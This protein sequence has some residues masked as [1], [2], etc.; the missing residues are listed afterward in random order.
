M[1]ITVNRPA[2]RTWNFLGVNGAKIEWG[3]GT[4]LSETRLSLPA[5]KSAGRLSAVS[6]PEGEY[7]EKRIILDTRPGEEVTLLE[8]VRGDESFLTRLEINAESDTRVRVLQL[9]MPGSDAVLRHESELMLGSG[10]EVSFITATLGD[11]DIYADTHCE[12]SGDGASFSSDIGYLCRGENRINVNLTVE[13]T[14]KNTECRIDASG[15]LTDS[16]KKDFCGTIDFKK[17][18]S[19]SHGAENETV[20]LLGEGAE[21][22]TLPVILCAEENVEGT[23]GATVGELDEPTLFYFESRGIS[24][25]EAE[26]MM[27]RAAIVRVAS[28]SRDEEYTDAVLSALD[29]LLCSPENGGTADA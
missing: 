5:D 6:E 28:L 2:S 22:K 13:H 15:A 26:R 4:E 12:L 23:H 11:G 27:A 25:E 7:S 9:F 10:A 17:G 8:T 18:C 3:E 16:A 21:N 1:N 19:G 24:R 29:A 14:G 20:L